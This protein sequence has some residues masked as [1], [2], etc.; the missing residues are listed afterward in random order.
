MLIGHMT[1][2]RA[3]A[4]AGDQ[5]RETLR[6]CKKTQGESG[7]VLLHDEDASPNASELSSASL[8]DVYPLMATLPDM[9]KPTIREEEMIKCTHGIS[10]GDW[11]ERVSK[12]WQQVPG[13]PPGVSNGEES[14][15]QEFAG[16]NNRITCRWRKSERSIV[17]MKRGNARGAKGLYVSHVSIKKVR[18]A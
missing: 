17:A 1:F 16:I 5:A 18:A 9:P 3:M 13:E 7:L 2:S 8:H 15:I 6:S 14:V 10:R 11:R 4:C 12:D